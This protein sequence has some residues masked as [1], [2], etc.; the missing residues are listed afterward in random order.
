MKKLRLSCFSLNSSWVVSFHILNISWNIKILP[1]LMREGVQKTAP[2][3]F[4]LLLNSFYHGIGFYQKCQQSSFYLGYPLLLSWKMKEIIFKNKSNVLSH[5]S[6]EIGRMRHIV[7]HDFLPR[8]YF[9]SKFET[10]YLFKTETTCL[11]FFDHFF[12]SN[13]STSLKM[14]ESQFSL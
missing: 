5:I 11:S 6:T 1:N 7:T 14:F 12:F 13:Q 4:N 9:S 3:L 10:I 2:R 8:N